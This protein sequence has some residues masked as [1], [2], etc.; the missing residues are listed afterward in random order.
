MNYVNLLSVGVQ[1]LFLLYKWTGGGRH[2]LKDD[3]P[4]E[5]VHQSHDSVSS[6]RTEGTV[7]YRLLIIIKVCILHHLLFP[8]HWVLHLQQDRQCTYNAASRRVRVL[9][10]VLSLSH[11]LSLSHKRQDFRENVIEYKLCVLIFSTILSET[12]LRRTQRDMIIKANK[13][14]RK[15]PVI[16]GRF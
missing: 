15:V 6:N 16:L 14:S 7:K 8:S 3:C 4:T 12:F 9:I 1:I 5:F 2:M 11:Y 13:S 10:I